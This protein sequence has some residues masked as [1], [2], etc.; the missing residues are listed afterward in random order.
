MSALPPG[1]AEEKAAVLAALVL[2]ALFV[3]ALPFAREP[4]PRADAFVP[5]VATV[6]LLTDATSA[7]LLFG[8]F[9]VLRS[10]SLLA[11]A[12]GYLFT[13][14]L[15]VPYALG[16]PGAFSPRGLL[17]GGLQTTGW[18]FVLWHLGLPASVVAYALLN[19]APSKIR[20]SRLPVPTAIGASVA[21]VLLLVVAV[22][23]A[24]IAFNDRLPVLVI[25][26]VRLSGLKT[27]VVSVLVLCVAAVSLLLAWRRSILDLW[28]LVVSFAWL[29]DSCFMYLT[30]A[31]YTVSWYAN[32]VFGVASACAVLFVL[33]AESTRLYASLALSVLA[34]L[35]EREGRLMSLEAMCAAIEHEIRQPIGAM[36]ANASAARRWLR[37][38]P[39]H[40]EEACE[41]VSSIE[42]DVDRA[43]GVVRSVRA[44]FE[45]HPRPAASALDAN[46]LIRET[47]ALV[48]ADVDAARVM[49][50]LE[51]APRLPRI[52]AHRGELQQVLLNLVRNAIEA[53]PGAA[54]RAS[55]LT[56]AT[57]TV[58]PNAVA[59]TVRDNG[60]GIDPANAERIFDAFFTTKPNGMGMGLA[61]CR[62]IV[63]AQRGTLSFSPARP[64]GAAFHLVLPVVQAATPLAV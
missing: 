16:F 17:G 57:G 28:L 26:L 61:I 55:V 51:L 43:I 2:F 37:R 29:L 4:L 15:V 3:A 14:L 52:A 8:Q 58:A 35:R 19:R 5:I 12:S 9:S 1:R 33:L 45:E 64:H 53:M 11:L 24:T 7:V 60:T 25:D 21:I 39:S 10:R 47:L 49:V 48:R 23:W 20:L 59:L 50:E 40:V 31:R 30:E 38:S 36:S 62:S 13:A 54:D 27:V 42:A 56:L 63:Q 22:T 41:A 34:Q 18:I 46:D 44:L 32:R 6:M